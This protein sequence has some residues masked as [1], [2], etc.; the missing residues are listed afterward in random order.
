MLT[1]KGRPTV[2]KTLIIP[3]MNHLILTLPNP[4]KDFKNLETE[5]L[6]QF[7]DPRCRFY[8]LCIYNNPKVYCSNFLGHLS[9]SGD[10]LLWVGVRRRASCVNNFF[11]RT[12]G[13]ILTKYGM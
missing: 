4:D 10:L 9:H 1:P 12:T 11:S 2:I 5:I 3:K 13:T 8:S 7:C 6:R